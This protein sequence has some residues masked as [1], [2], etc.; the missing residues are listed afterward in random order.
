MNGHTPSP[1]A[2]PTKTPTR[3]VI[4]LI[5]VSVAVATGLSACAAGSPEA[6]GIASPPSP[7]ASATGPDVVDLAH[8]VRGDSVEI[9]VDGPLAVDQRVITL[10]PGQSTGVHCHYGRLL[11]V[12]EQGELTHYADIYPDGVHVYR[13][14]DAIDEGSGYVHEGRNEGDVDTVLSVT[15]VTPEGAPLAETDLE[16]CD[17]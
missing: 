16:K 9:R 10:H 6:T 3:T 7:S 4:A 14:G 1:S 2:T 17:A 12:V 11:G 15:Y 5:A 13:T 8:G